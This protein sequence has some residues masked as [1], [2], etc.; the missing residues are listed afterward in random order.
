[1][2]DLNKNI[3]NNIIINDFI[4]DD[5]EKNFLEYYFLEKV[6]Y[7]F[8]R[9]TTYKNTFKK[10]KNVNDSPQLTH[11]YF[12]Y[13]SR[14]QKCYSNSEFSK[15]TLL[16][17]KKTFNFF[18]LNN[19]NLI[20][21]KSNL[22]IQNENK[23]SSYHPPHVDYTTNHFVMLYYVNNSDGDTHFFN[24]DNKMF[25]SCKPKKGRIVMFDGSILH[26]SSCPSKTEA[27]CVLNVNFYKKKYD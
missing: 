14:E 2:I 18:C 4:F 21:A 7:F 5:F 1:M 11:I 15:V 17:I 23:N 16:V 20:R 26:S 24:K 25:Y 3:E 6:P 19:F 13:N 12:G 10:D 22:I 9:G 27:R 8:N